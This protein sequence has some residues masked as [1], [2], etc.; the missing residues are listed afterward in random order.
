MKLEV[1]LILLIF[2]IFVF[3]QNRSLTIGPKDNGLVIGNSKQCNGIRLN[4]W[5]KNVERVNGFNLSA[6]TASNYTNGLSFGLTSNQDSVTNGV[7][8][9]GLINLGENFNGVCI[10]GLGTAAN[11]INGL[12]I[13]GLLT[14]ADT[15]NGLFISG[16]GA[17]GGNGS[18]YITAI[19]GISIG[20][21]TT[22]SKMNGLSVGFQSVTDTIKG[23]VIGFVNNESKAANGIQVGMH[24][25]TTDL[26]GLQIGFWNISENNRY[27]KKTPIINF[28]FRKKASR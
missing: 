28:N 27:L 23:V 26:Y 15:M 12:G 3:G 18:S 22:C 2:P 8:I 17:F 5:D 19:N 4:F 21:F 7:R 6:K 1:I 14:Y 24:N 11:K 16:L 10:G 9:G 20:M 13:G 25:K